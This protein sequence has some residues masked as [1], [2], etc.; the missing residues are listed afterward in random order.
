MDYA[1]RKSKYQTTLEADVQEKSQTTFEADVKDLIAAR[2]C[3]FYTLHAAFLCILKLLSSLTKLVRVP[4]SQLKDVALSR[5]TKQVG[6]MCVFG[7][8][9]GVLAFKSWAAYFG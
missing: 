2:C 8:L 3:C 6:P 1:A 7:S 9:C 4:V 5:L